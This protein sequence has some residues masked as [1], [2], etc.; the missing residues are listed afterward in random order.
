M[1]WSRK[2]GEVAGIGIYVHATFLLLIAWVLLTHFVQGASLSEALAELVFIL[3]LFAS[4]VFHELAHSLT[5]RRFGIQTRDITLLPIGGVAQLERM[6]QDPRQSF[7][8]ALAGPLSS[9]GLAAVLYIVLWVSGSLQ[10]LDSLNPTGG[11]FLQQLML[12][13]LSLALFNLLPAF[14]MD[15]GRVFQALLAGRIGSNRAT[16][17]AA[18]VGQAMAV[19][20]GLAGLVF[21]PSLLLIAFF[22][23]I[24]AGQEAANARMGSSLEG[25]PVADAMLRDFRTLPD[26]SRLSDAADLVI[27]CSQQD[28]PV[29]SNNRLV[30]VLTWNDLI[31]ALSH[32]GPGTPVVT[33]MQR[34]FVTV[35]AQEMLDRVWDKLQESGSR[36]ALV[37]QGDRLVGLLTVDNV[38][39]FLVIRRAVRSH[40]AGRPETRVL[41]RAA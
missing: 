4:V 10:P 30:G 18:S 8:V 34:D 17:V 37:L 6:P 28:F 35:D 21:N 24:G 11:S 15:G 12:T 29:V 36:T 38:A 19:L 25:I 40:S 32:Q 33:V 14:P 39:E 23:W 5:A 31:S 3:A 22:I 9:L 41:A 7:W 20:F 26:S 2:I 27:D 16:Q 1:K 13:N